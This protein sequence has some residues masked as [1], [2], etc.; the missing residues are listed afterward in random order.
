MPD[1]PTPPERLWKYR[2]WDQYAANMI[3]HGELY[4]ARVQQLND[5]YEF[6]WRH[7]FPISASQIDEYARQFCAKYST[8]DPRQ[9]RLDFES[10][11]AYLASIAEDNSGGVIPSAVVFQYG[12][13]CLSAVNNNILM[14][15]HYARNHTGIC[16]GVRPSCLELH[17]I[18]PVEYSEKI[19]IIDAWEYINDGAEA[20][21]TAGRTKSIDWKYEQEWRMVHT[22]R[23][24]RYPGCIDQ[25]IVGVMA[26]EQTRQAAIEAAEAAPHHVDVFECR[27]S[28]GRY[29]VDIV[30]M[31][32]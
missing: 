3:I 5:I 23:V 7:R 24:H 15:A 2:T 26:S 18:L 21:V 32:G 17:R 12:V 16:L 22:P 9:R 13:C 6:Y 27:R 4:F 31:S 1:D 8:S 30:P 14:W 20:F 19:P 28:P 11:K 10:V 25:I 29:R